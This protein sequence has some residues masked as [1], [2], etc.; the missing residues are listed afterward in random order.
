MMTTNRTRATTWYGS[1]SIQYEK[2]NFGG[3]LLLLAIMFA[4]VVGG[5]LLGAV[6]ARAASPQE[7][8]KTLNQNIEQAISLL[9]S[10]DKTGAQAAYKKFDDGWF[11]IEDGIK[12][13]SRPTYKAI[14]D[15]MG[16]IKF[17]FN[18]QPFDQAKALESLQKL[19]SLNEAFISG[20]TSA[21]SGQTE[22]TTASNSKPTFK[23]LMS[24]LDSAQS[25]LANNDVN[26]AATAIKEF[27]SE[28]P[29]L[30]TFVSA[31]SASAY[32]SIENNMARAYA[33]LK[34]TP[35]D[36]EGAKTTINQLKTDLT[37]YLD[38][39]SYGIFDAM[40]VLLREGLEAL[41]VMAALLTFMS[42]SGNADKR[43]VIWAGAALGIG[44]SLVVAIIMQMIFANVESAGTNR[45]LIEGITGLVAAGMLFYMS[46]WLH[47]KSNV[48]GWQRYI[49]SKSSAAL[50]TGSAF[51]LGLLAFLA[52]FRE[53]AETVLLY[54]GIAPS[55]SL[56]DLL[57]GIGIALVGLVVLA[58]LILVVGMKLPMRPFF[59][60]ASILIYYIG[61]KFIGTGVHALQVAGII[62]A[63]STSYLPESGF[64]GIYPTWETTGAQLALLAATAGVLV[65]MKVRDRKL[66]RKMEGT[67]S[68]RP[69]VA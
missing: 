51:S 69:N 33:Q 59:M 55:I 35:A 4:G 62:P 43:K 6:V 53:G 8:L 7:D 57:I 9:Q 12:A 34:S 19:D 24:H 48:S 5:I 54:M 28:W 18:L 42:K 65:W 61:F 49:K 13:V 27:Q 2:R 63:T 50:A 16:D 45:E 47:S 68:A 23:T 31:K 46:Y 66:T 58:V 60:V 36:V 14:E 1:G 3:R 29:S 11:E 67:S 56:S 40:T 20:N 21:T 52:V 30:E 44:A 10:G 32:S 25:A 37:P 64:F 26:K 38:N 41:L 17:A 15:A 22:T 39:N